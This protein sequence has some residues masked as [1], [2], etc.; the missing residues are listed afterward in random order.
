MSHADADR[1]DYLERDIAALAAIFPDAGVILTPAFLNDLKGCKEHDKKKFGQLVAEF[2]NAIMHGRLDKAELK[3]LRSLALKKAE[4]WMVVAT[5]DSDGL[6][7]IFP[8]MVNSVL[9]LRCLDYE[10]EDQSEGLQ[11]ELSL[12]EFYDEQAVEDGL[13]E[14]YQALNDLHVAHGGSGL[15]VEEGEAFL[16]VADGAEVTK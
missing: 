9:A 15:R 4:Q 10:D 3:R 8:S 16:G 12:P 6:G 2:R 7:A 13:V 5:E 1:L 11:I 14:L